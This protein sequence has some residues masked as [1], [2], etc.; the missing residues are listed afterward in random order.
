VGPPGNTFGLEEIR[1]EGL[2]CPFALTG[3]SLLKAESCESS[4]H[5][6]VQ[7]PRSSRSC[8][9]LLTC[10]P[11]QA[12]GKDSKSHGSKKGELE[13]AQNWEKAGQGEGKLGSETDTAKPPC[14]LASSGCSQPSV[15]CSD[16]GSS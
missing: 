14:L 1:G 6:W 15:L 7:S 10:G 11:Q 9:G 16:K 2:R 3:Q 8:K 12:S 13:N 5:D 4:C